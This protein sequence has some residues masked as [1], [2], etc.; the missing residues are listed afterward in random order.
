MGFFYSRKSGKTIE[1]DNEELINPFNGAD[2]FLYYMVGVRDNQLV[3]AM[4]PSQL[5]DAVEEN[6]DILIPEEAAK[7]D[8]VLKEVNLGS[9]NPILIFYTLK[10]F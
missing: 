9:G 6:R 4:L 3:F 10:D 1:F 2:L 8:A 7:V 5:A